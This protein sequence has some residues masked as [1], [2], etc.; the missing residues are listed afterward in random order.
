MTWASQNTRPKKV[1]IKD[2]I[3]MIDVRMCNDYLV[4]LLNTP[5]VAEMEQGT[6]DSITS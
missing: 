2:I 4:Q 5:I 3:D 6:K 1:E